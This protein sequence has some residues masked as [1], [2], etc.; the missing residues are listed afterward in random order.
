[1]H[2]IS[3]RIV[4]SP[5][6]GTPGKAGVAVAYDSGA[7]DGERFRIEQLWTEGRA[8]PVYVPEDLALELACEI[9]SHYEWEVADD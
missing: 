4:K 2:S 1:M 9:I 3:R 7:Q 8:D 6:H 5:E